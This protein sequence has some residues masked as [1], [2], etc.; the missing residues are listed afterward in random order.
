[1]SGMDANG[2]TIGISRLPVLPRV[3]EG[4]K[5]AQVAT[6]KKLILKGHIFWGQDVRIKEE[7]G[8]EIS[9]GLDRGNI[10]ATALRA[11]MDGD[12][13]GINGLAGI[14]SQNLGKE[15]HILIIANRF[16]VFQSGKYLSPHHPFTL[17]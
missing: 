2:L 5:K 12:R 9:G 15:N 11:L 16:R 3:I 14:E 7:I 10:M 1:M 17:G 8:D 6:G 13:I 4:P